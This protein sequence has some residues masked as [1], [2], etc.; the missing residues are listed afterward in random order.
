MGRCALLLTRSE[1]A[2]YQR[3]R[4]R[5]EQLQDAVES[6]RGITLRTPGAGLLP[7]DVTAAL[8]VEFY[9]PTPQ[10]P[11]PLKSHPLCVLRLAAIAAVA[12]RGLSIPT[13]KCSPYT[14]YRVA[15]R[16]ATPRARDHTSGIHAIGQRL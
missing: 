2:G 3:T 11:T 12:R 14:A 7:P 13:S 1:K 10:A 6:G 4:L 9:V 8:T 16:E 15:V 5:A